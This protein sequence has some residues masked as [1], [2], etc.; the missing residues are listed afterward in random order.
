MQFKTRSIQYAATCLIEST[1]SLCVL[2]YENIF[3]KFFEFEKFFNQEVSRI[4]EDYL[5]F[6]KQM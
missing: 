5:E 1:M 4:S 2:N 3:L 6:S